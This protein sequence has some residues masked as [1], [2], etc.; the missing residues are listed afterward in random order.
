MLPL[1]K[2]IQF[3]AIQTVKTNFRIPLQINDSDKHP[4]TNTYV[5]MKGGQGKTRVGIE[6]AASFLKDNPHNDYVLIFANKNGVLNDEWA[7]NLKMLNISYEVIDTPK[8]KT[9][10]LNRSQK[11]LIRI[12]NVK[13]FLIT[14][15]FFSEKIDKSKDE[16]NSIFF[17]NSRPGL[18]IFDEFSTVTN[19]KD[20]GILYSEI[21]K[22]C[23]DISIKKVALSATPYDNTDDDKKNTQLGHIRKLLNNL[24][25]DNSSFDE[26]FF[27]FG[28]HN[29]KTRKN[30]LSSELTNSRFFVRINEALK[31]TEEIISL[32]RNLLEKLSAHENL[33]AKLKSKNSNYFKPE[34]ICKSKEIFIKEL[35]NII[36]TSRFQKVIIFDSSLK[37][38]EYLKRQP[39][40]KELNPVMYTG[41]QSNEKKEESKN[42]FCNNAENR[43][44]LTTRSISSKGLN[45]QVASIVIILGNAREEDIAQMEFR[46]D[47]NGQSNNTFSFILF[48][49]D[50]EK[51]KNLLDNSNSALYHPQMIF[52]EKDENLKIEIQNELKNLLFTDNKPVENNTDKINGFDFSHFGT[53]NKTLD[54]RYISNCLIDEKIYDSDR[55]R[56]IMT[57][58]TNSVNEGK[59]YAETV[60]SNPDYY[61]RLYDFYTAIEN[62][63]FE[64]YISLKNCRWTISPGTKEFPCS[65]HCKTPSELLDLTPSEIFFIARPEM[66]TI[67]EV[68]LKNIS[69]II[70]NSAITSG[71]MI[72]KQFKPGYGRRGRPS[73]NTK[74]LYQYLIASLMTKKYDAFY[75][76]PRRLEEIEEYIKIWKENPADNELSRMILYL[77]ESFFK[78]QVPDSANFYNLLKGDKLDEE[79]VK[80]FHSL[81]K[82]YVY[83][84]R[85]ISL[86]QKETEFF[87]KVNIDSL[88]ENIRKKIIFLLDF[89][90]YPG[91]NTS[92]LE[93]FYRK[94]VNQYYQPNPFFEKSSADFIKESLIFIR[95]NYLSVD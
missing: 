40:I 80:Y 94:E 87:E 57:F 28:S 50:E 4:F 19:Q 56:K 2:D 17:L 95:E 59:I 26:K 84:F 20:D 67:T 18:I 30:G 78:N 90:Y 14:Y 8:K 72:D 70:S 82:A 43:I 74:L 1:L 81:L 91:R 69:K 49:P 63:N 47:R 93:D 41:N 13:I 27:F 37:S 55:I 66:E 61:S 89:I 35:L 48:E 10:Y 88:P 64:K 52:S 73:N 34:T 7:R 9:L 46:I 24:K 45:L 60:P 31:E 76:N 68:A 25:T 51:H 83:P 16:R 92:E 53:Y 21:K 3:D 22:I 33:P 65:T 79:H 5:V 44:L 29:Y 77:I 86:S 11:R 12:K 54:L 42:L 75:N 62:S 6:I 23:E 38:L 36:K 15:E 85:I 39:W 58:Y 32:N 71:M